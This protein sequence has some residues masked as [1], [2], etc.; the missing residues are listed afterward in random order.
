MEK[1]DILTLLHS[2]VH[3]ETGSDIVSSGI[4]QN[5]MVTGDKIQFILNFSRRRD[6][7]AASIKKQAERA[8]AEQYPEYAGKIT[9]YLKESKEKEGA[10]SKPKD[11]LSGI[12]NIVA[13][14]SAKG[15]VGKSTVTAHLALALAESGNKVGIL[16]A[17]IYGPSQPMLFGL[18]DYVLDGGKDGS[19]NDIIFPAKTDGIKIMSIGFFINPD[20]ALVWRGPMATTALKQMIHQTDW[21]EL[22]Y[23]LIDL[24]P[25][26]GDIHLSIISEM[27]VSG[28]VIV[29]TPQELA[30]ADVV[31][32]ISMFRGNH[33]DIPVLGIIE[34]MSW[35][36]PAELPDKR[37]YIF[38]K[39]GVKELAKKI[40][41][42]LLAEIPLLLP[43]NENPVKTVNRKNDVVNNFYKTLARDI[44]G[45]LREINK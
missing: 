13:V 12:K 15:G 17:D 23:L 32:G 2:V 3:P 30:L 11:S 39:G 24:P 25:G 10:A 43:E 26:T 40:D 1:D 33:V 27:K 6:P 19:G 21:G 18:E 37:Y 28:A 29:S 16:D 41:I 31:R 36:T 44:T 4:V 34:N 20:D 8:I 9:V 42:P 45:R 35:F 22:D 14:S 7:F 5:L 38:G